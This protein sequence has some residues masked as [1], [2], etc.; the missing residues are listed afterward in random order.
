[1]MLQ[2]SCHGFPCMSVSCFYG[3]PLMVF[4]VF[5]CLVS[6][7][8]RLWFFLC[9]CVQFSILHS[10]F[11]VFPGHDYHS[12]Y[13]LPMLLQ[14]SSIT[15]TW[16]TLSVFIFSLPLF[17]DSLSVIVSVKGCYCTCC[18]LLQFN[19]KIQDNVNGQFSFTSIILFYFTF[20]VCT[21]ML[22]EKW[23][24][25]QMFKQFRMVYQMR[26]LCIQDL[27]AYLIFCRVI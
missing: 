27:E 5:P 15:H 18:V 23:N 21:V 2:C 12:I 8:I 22:V 11:L 19:F 25:V 13:G 6:S 7:V 16:F 24:S 4:L 20:N 26:V 10:W 17:F 3:I 9:L 14:F 1:M